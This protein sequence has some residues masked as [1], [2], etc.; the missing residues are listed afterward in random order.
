VA[1]VL[2]TLATVTALAATP[3]TAKWPPWLSIESPVNP[4]DPATRGAALLVH[5]AFREGPAQLADITGSAE[6]MVN[7]VRRTLPLRFAATNQMNVFALSRQWPTD[8]V[9]LLRIALRT[10]TAVV[11]LDRAGNVASVSVPTELANGTAVPRAV[12]GKEIDSAL[13]VAAR[14]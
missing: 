5:A 1:L 3:T 12:A 11:T 7:G 13:A 9:W 10:T 4:F 6:G 2:T 8:G 14:R